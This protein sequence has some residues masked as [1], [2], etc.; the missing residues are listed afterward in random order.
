MTMLVCV[1]GRDRNGGFFSFSRVSLLPLFLAFFFSMTCPLLSIPL[2]SLIFMASSLLW[3]ARY[4]F[5]FLFLS[6][7]WV[8]E[9]GVEGLE[10]FFVVMVGEGEGGRGVGGFFFVT[11]V[12]ERG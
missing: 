12:G 2:A 3:K 11:M 6:Q 4:S 10:V 7:W 8:K 5:L 1:G 9:K